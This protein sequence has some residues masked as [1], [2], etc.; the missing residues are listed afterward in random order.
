MRKRASVKLAV[1]VVVLIGVT[2]SVA[3]MASASA[4]SPVPVAPYTGYNPI[5]TRAPYVTDLAQTSASV[6]WA[7][8]SATPGSVLAAPT[9][10]GSSCPASVDTWS[11]SA[12][13]APTSLPSPVNPINAVVSAS[14]TSRQFTVNGTSEYQSSV[15]LSGLTPGT[16][17]CYAVFS[18]NGPG[19]VDL[20]PPTEPVQFFTTLNPSSAQA[21]TPVSFDV[22]DDTGENYYYTSRTHTTDIPFPSGY[23]PNQASLYHQIGQSGASFLVSAGDIAYSGATQ[24]NFG[25][26]QQTGTQPEVSNIFGSF[27]Y[28]QTGGIPIFTGP[29]DHGQNINPL[30][31]FPTSNTAAASGGTYAYDSYSGTDGITGASPDSWYAFSTGNVRVYVL[32]GAWSESVANKLGTTTGSLCGAANSPQALYCLPYQ[33]DADLH[34]QPSSPEYQWLQRDLLA[35]PGGVKMAVIHNPI[36]SDN[37]TQ[38]SDVYLQNSSANPSASTSLE[39][40]LT[41]NGVQLAFDGHAHTYQRIVPNGPGQLTNYVTGGGG[42]VLEPVLGGATCTNLTHGASAPYKDIYAIGW[43]P[44]AGLGSSCSTNNNI[45]APAAAADVYNFLKVTVSGTTVTVTPYN[46]AGTTFDVQTYTYPATGGPSTPAG[47]T[48]AATSTTSVALNWAA[49]AEAGGSIAS[50]RIYRNGSALTSV[51][52]STTSFTDTGAQPGTTYTYSVAAVDGAGR[53]SWPG[54]ANLVTTPAQVQASPGSGQPGCSTHLPSG[55]VVAAAASVDGS[56]YYEV[57]KYGDVAA[58]GAAS[59]YGGMTGTPLNRPIV[60]MAVDPTTGGYWLVASDGG[61]F[62]FNA[63]FRG[64]TGNLRLNKPI[65]AMGAT[66]DGAGYWLVASDGGVFS[67]NATFYGGTGLMKLNKPIVGMAVD[68]VTGGYWLVASDGGVFNFNAPFDGATGG[69]KLN[70]PIVGI[71]AVSDGSGYRLVAS[72]GGVFTGFNM[73][74]YGGTGL[75]RLN[76]PIVT[77]INDNNGDGYWL[78]ASDGGVFSFHAPFYGSAAG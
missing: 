8:T 75:I 1:G 18:G 54:A 17:Y 69:M 34:W 25:D 67:F 40:L 6:N 77:T 51:G 45:P 16:Q 76:R 52:A 56:G 74:F 21:A 11:M 49:S 65:V 53:L 58:F 70:Q 47:V 33:A 27:Y 62:S 71:D 60:G 35:H 26:L 72:D 10:S 68:Q 20:L 31:V 41:A 59:C 57:D 64:S 61:V 46:A 12:A 36:R 43:N 37:A 50:Y 55:S 19:S 4:D 5:L 39:A 63:P 22:V 29:G 14:L 38:P 3:L 9:G 48:A 7:T 15:S 66:P 28:P 44:T 32:D 2:S 30:K 73:P 78:V 13:S 24:S 42:G 23:N